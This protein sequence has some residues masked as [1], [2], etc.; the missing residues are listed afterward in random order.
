MATLSEIAEDM[1]RQAKSR[2]ASVRDLPRGLSL[3]LTWVGG[4]KVLRLS[5]PA[6]MPGDEEIDICR[7]A[8]GVPAG[9]KEI[10]ETNLVTMRWPS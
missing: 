6:V 5:R 9:V 4:Y 2:G 7:R 10:R 3:E 1:Q 8:F